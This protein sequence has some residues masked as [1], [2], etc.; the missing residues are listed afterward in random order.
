MIK[1]RRST[2]AQLLSEISPWN[3]VAVALAFV[4][5]VIMN[6]DILYGSTRQNILSFILWGVLDGTNGVAAYVGGGNYVLQV[7]YVLG[8]TSVIICLVKS[9]KW[10]VEWAWH[11]SAVVTLA[12]IAN[13]GF[14]LST[15]RF[16]AIWSTVGVVVAGWP[17]IKDGWQDPYNQPVKVYLGFTFVNTFATIA[18]TAWTVEER[19]Y[20]A[21]CIPLCLA[22][23]I[24]PL[25]SKNWGY[26]REVGSTMRAD[27]GLD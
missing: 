19:L 5:Y 23:A 1:S 2:L 14:L 22:T 21:T 3:W 10:K 15:A 7:A 18:G 13:A 20:P 17:L 25:V 6:R 12:L 16:A 26:L 8:C 9:G 24:V 11:E 27:F 4:L